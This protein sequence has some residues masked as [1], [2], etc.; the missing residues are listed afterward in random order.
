MDSIEV[1]VISDTHGLLRP[2]AAAALAGV[3]LI[4]HGGDVGAR[5]IVEA[6]SRIAPVMCVRGNCDT[7]EYGLTLPLTET[8][9]VGGI[10]IF[11]HHGHN[12]L[13][14]DPELAGMNVVVSGHT[15][16]PRL[17]R[18]N[19]VLWMNPG[20]AGPERFNLPATLGRLSVR[21]GAVEAR[22]LNL[23]DGSELSFL[24]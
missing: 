19:G 4:L 20:S 7:D 11:M 23:R 9:S 24:S 6:L 13:E 1:G 22:L 18:G 15:H 12:R 14:I 8:V 5:E 3:S 21:D 17:S 16:V 10:R 2:E